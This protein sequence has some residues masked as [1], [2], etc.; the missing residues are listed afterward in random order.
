MKFRIALVT[1]GLGL[2]AAGCTPA[3]TGLMPDPSE[4]AVTWIDGAAL[5]EGSDASV[6]LA[7]GEIVFRGGCNSFMGLR[8]D[9]ASGVISGPAQLGATM[10]ACP[11]AQ[12]AL[13]DAL[14]AALRRV[15]GTAIPV[16][17]K[18]GSI[19]LTSGGRAVVVLAPI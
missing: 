9:P 4:W 12:M 15:D 11:Q 14:G 10:M 5:P 7:N 19:A 16:G 1:L 13:D 18:E 8:R 2:A 3:G 6:S 17:Q